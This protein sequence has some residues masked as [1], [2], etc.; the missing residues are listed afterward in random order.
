M[1]SKMVALLPI[2]VK[3]RGTMNR[4]FSRPLIHDIFDI[5][6]QNGVTS[7]QFPEGTDGREKYCLPYTPTSSF[8]GVMDPLYICFDRV[9]NEVER[10]DASCP[11]L[12]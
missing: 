5:L 9:R 8:L 10:L 3:K 7:A 11:S 4:I 6:N 2:N 12:E 1:P